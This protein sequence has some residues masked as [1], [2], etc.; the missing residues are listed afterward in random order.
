MKLAASLLLCCVLAGIPARAVIP[1]ARDSDLSEIARVATIM[2]DGD[3]CQ[4]IL[5]PRALAHMLHADP[6]DP[7]VGG[8]NYDVNEGAFSSTKKTL[9]RLSMMASYPVDVNLWM[10]LPTTP[11]DVYVVIRNKYN[12][13]QFWDGE[14][15][16]KMPPAMQ[17]VLKTGNSI[18]IK[19]KPGMVS[20]LSPVR[21]SLGE[22]VGLVEVV[23]STAPPEH[24]ER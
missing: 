19:E 11:P 12:L 5:T 23:S 1:G 22:I 10:P 7:W 14:L 4:R 15:Q 2:M 3:L 13:S 21:N 20:V 24:D 9:M 16:Q 18:T 8:D 6:R 17:Q